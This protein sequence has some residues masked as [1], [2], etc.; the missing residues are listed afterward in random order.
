MRVG[1]RLELVDEFL[2]A[3]SFVFVR[4]KLLCDFESVVI[5]LEVDQRADQDHD[6]IDLKRILQEQFPDQRLG[7]FGS[8]EGH[9][10]AA[11]SLA[12]LRASVWLLREWLDDG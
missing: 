3:A 1:D 10:S 8:A 6:F 9:Q 7:F 2:A 5:F 4:V 11:I 12:M